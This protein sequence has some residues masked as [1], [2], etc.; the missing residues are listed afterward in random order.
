MF[1]FSW[2]IFGSGTNFVVILLAVVE[3]ALF[4]KA[5][6]SV[7]SSWIGM[8][9]GRIVLHVNMHGLTEYGT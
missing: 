6:G 1:Y 8:K 5:V 9:F 4:K 7:V 3:A 2:I